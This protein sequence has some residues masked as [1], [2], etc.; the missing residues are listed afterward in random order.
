MTPAQLAEWLEHFITEHEDDV[1]MR[2]L[3]ILD[4]IAKHL[5]PREQVSG[6]DA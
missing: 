1:P 4:V 2:D 3:V 5:D 6:D